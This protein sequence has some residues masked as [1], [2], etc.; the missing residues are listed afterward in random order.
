MIFLLFLL[1]GCGEI[2]AILVLLLVSAGLSTVPEFFLKK[3]ARE[4][5]TK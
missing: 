1:Q 5:Q 3:K 2:P 4:K